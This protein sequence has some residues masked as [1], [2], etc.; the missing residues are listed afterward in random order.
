MRQIV[1]CK[2]QAE[3][4]AAIAAGHTA[5]VFADSWEAPAGSHVVAWGGSHVEARE[6]SHVEARESSHVEASGSSHVEARESSHVVAWGSSHVVAWGSVAVH[7]QSD[8]AVVDLFGFAVAVVLTKIAKVVK[9][10]RT[11]SIVTPKTPAGAAGWLEGQ[12]VKAE[13]KHVVL[14]K[15]VSKDWQ[16]QENTANATTWAVGATLVHP[17]WNPKSG[18]CGE[19]KYHACSMAYFCDEFR[20]KKD[21]RYVAL[22]VAVKDLY[23]WPNA[24]YPHKIAF[25]AAEV[26]HECDRYGKKVETTEA[27]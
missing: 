3:F 8:Y 23:A 11:A 18:E 27:A 12:G 10:S 20:D 16:T 4:K 17:S 5:R 6:S 7:V 9:K 26:L 13:K 1:D 14:Y 15:R 19:G 22:K 24:S 2:T 21:D 25:R